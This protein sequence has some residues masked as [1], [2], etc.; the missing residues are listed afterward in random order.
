MFP[1]KVDSQL[2]LSYSTNTTLNG[3]LKKCFARFT[4]GDPVVISAG[5]V[6]AHQT[7]PLAGVILLLDGVL[8]NTW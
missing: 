6:P 5:H 1:G 4:R 3:S 8:T 7:G 2:V